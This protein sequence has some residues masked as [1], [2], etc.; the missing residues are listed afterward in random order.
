M[1]ARATQLDVSVLTIGA[2]DYL[3]LAQNVTLTKNVATSEGQAI[4]R[5]YA[6]PQ[7]VKNSWSLSG[8]FVVTKTAPVRVTNLDLTAASIL[9]SSYVAAVE[10]LTMNV[11]ATHAPGDACEDGW[12]YP[13]Y[14]GST[15]DGTATLKVP[16]GSVPLM[17]AL[18]AP[19][20]A[21]G[22]FTFTLNGNTVTFPVIITSLAH[23]ASNGQ[24]QTVTV[25]FQGQD[26]LTGN[27][28]TAPTGTTTIVEKILNAPQ[29]ALAIAW[30]TKSS[31]G[32]AYTGNALIQ[33]YS[34]NISNGSVVTENMTWAGVGA[35]TD[36][37]S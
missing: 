4:N 8:S 35:S 6:N 11:N 32:V 9:G 23:A 1:S 5:K 36:A 12:A 28:P 31:N 17:A 20:D 3:G 19:G 22:V 18:D 33:S 34:V 15:I 30:T 25:N 13:V 26:P 7:A 2:V 24:V 21:D 29:T 14:T 27:M 37:A 10:S 16:A